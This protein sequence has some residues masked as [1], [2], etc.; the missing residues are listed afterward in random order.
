MYR[1]TTTLF[2]S[3]LEL[4]IRHPLEGT[5]DANRV[6]IMTMNKREGGRSRA[7]L[8]EPSTSVGWFYHNL[9]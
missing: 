2:S 8:D 4:G 6:P 3:L 9:S 1:Y 5:A 7:Y